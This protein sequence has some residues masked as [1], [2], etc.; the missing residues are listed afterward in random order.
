MLSIYDRQR[1]LRIRFEQTTSCVKIL[2]ELCKCGCYRSEHNDKLDLGHGACLTTQCHC[3]QFTWDGF[4]IKEGPAL[5]E[6][7][8]AC[9]IVLPEVL[10]MHMPEKVR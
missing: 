4:L 1:E 10:G 5:G 6:L 9:D 8:N 7:P 3:Q 2:D